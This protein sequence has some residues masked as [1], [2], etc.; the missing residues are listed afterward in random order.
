MCCS[1]RL[2]SRGAEE[3]RRMAERVKA[4]EAAQ[5]EA[6]QRLLRELEIVKAREAEQT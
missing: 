4:A 6:R 3:E 2:Q 1:V 5:F